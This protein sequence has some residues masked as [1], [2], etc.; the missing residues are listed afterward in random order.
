M[1]EYFLHYIWRYRAFDTCNAVTERGD[2]VEVVFPGNYNKLGGPDFLNAR[3]RIGETLW[4]GHVEVHV[5]ASDWRR[6]GHNGDEHYKNVILHV[7]YESDCD[8]WLRTPGDLQVLNVFRLIDSGSW[9]RYLRWKERESA[10]IV[11]E[12][13]ER[14][15]PEPV[16]THWRTRL[17]VERLE[18]KASAFQQ[19][20]EDNVMNWPE[21]FFFLLSRNFGFRSNAE[22][23]EMLARAVG[24]RVMEKYRQDLFQME[25]LLFGTAGF[26]ESE[27]GDAYFLKL[28]EEWK[29][30]KKK[31]HLRPLPPSVWNFGGIRPYNFPTVRIA[32]LAAFLTGEGNFLSLFLEEENIET[33]RNRFMRPASDYW[34]T[35]FHFSK[36]S[37]SEISTV[38]GP[39]AINNILLNTITVALFVFGKY[40]DRQ[41]MVDLALNIYE[42]C[43][44]E[45]NHIVKEWSSLG[46]KVRHAGDTQ[47][48]IQLYN[49]YCSP[50][51][52]LEC[53]LGHFL[54]KEENE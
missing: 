36:R 20:L 31:H 3:I 12:I 25:A 52:C 22:G 47:A 5:R 21:A 15:F 44:A 9:K 39:N 23:F 53:E 33:A 48:L 46:V 17:L 40:H 45:D 27:A 51:R 13:A 34:K 4:I 10:V 16:W 26:L 8:I 35:H 43:K 38:P 28:R 54:L 14:R 11:C 30:L 24:F 32:Q 1:N 7:V 41:K 37:V 50:K 6:H 29:Y 18:A 49:E 2:R 42:N 19:V